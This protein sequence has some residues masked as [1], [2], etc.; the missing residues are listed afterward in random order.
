LA[1][2]IDINDPSLASE[3]VEVDGVSGEEWNAI[4]VPDDGEHFVRL[5]LGDGKIKV[6]QQSA[7]K[8]G[9]YFLTAHLAEKIYDDSENQSGVLFDR[10]N[11]AI[12]ERNG[13]RGSGLHAL[14]DTIGDPLPNSSTLRDQYDQVERAIAQS[15]KV[16]AVTQWQASAKAETEGEVDAA[17]NAKYAKAGKLQVGN[18]YT[19]L[20]GQRRFPVIDGSDPVKYDPEV[21]NPITG[22]RVRAQAIVLRYKRA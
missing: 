9:R 16:I 6:G 11:S 12:F 10:V 5:E 19:F 14:M 2:E 15:P 1:T 13:K 18:Y 3:P 4:P 8:G 20:K 21:E 17:V 7:E 22:E